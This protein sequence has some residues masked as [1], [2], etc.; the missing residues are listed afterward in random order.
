MKSLKS[1]L[2]ILPFCFFA[3][4]LSSNKNAD[5]SNGNVHA[6]L[7]QKSKID[8]SNI[9]ITVERG[10]FHYDKFVLKDTLITFYP[11]K[12][13]IGVDNSDYNQISEKVISVQT[14]NNLVKKILN[15][16]FFKLKN[17]Y[18]SNTTCNS[19]LTVTV[20]F[21]NQLKKVISEDFDREC[22]E[23]LKF[24]EQEVIKMHNKELKRILLPG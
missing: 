13:N 9:E 11:S 8:S 20:K 6:A 17:F 24:I 2:C 10:A 4:N 1:L 7:E 16:G 15:D 18:A 23:L 3:C 22:P 12:E 5:N 21:N 14:R 19:H